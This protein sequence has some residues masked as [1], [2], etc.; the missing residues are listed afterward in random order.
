MLQLHFVINPIWRESSSSS[1]SVTCL[2]MRGFEVLTLLHPLSCLLSLALLTQAI[3]MDC[4]ISWLDS[5]ADETRER[6]DSKRQQHTA[7]Q[8]NDATARIQ[9]EQF[10]PSLRLLS[11]F[12][13]LTH[14]AVWWACHVGRS[15]YPSLFLSLCLTFPFLPPLNFY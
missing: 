6:G 8:D 5:R 14:I 7:L 1:S 11:T 10:P 4:S 15:A 12:L 13:H 3:C 2:L 9:T